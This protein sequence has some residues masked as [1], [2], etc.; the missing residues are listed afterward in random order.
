LRTQPLRKMSETLIGKL[1]ISQSEVPSRP[2]PEACD[3]GLLFVR[4]GVA[5]QVAVMPGAR[6]DLQPKW[7]AARIKAARHHDGGYAEDVKPRR[8]GVSKY[9]FVTIVDAEEGDVPDY[10]DGLLSGTPDL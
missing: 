7:K 8:V 1:F 6:G 4:V 2:A 9:L 3:G 10:S 5:K